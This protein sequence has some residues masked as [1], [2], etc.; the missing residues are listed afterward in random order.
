MSMGNMLL[1]EATKVCWGF[2]P[3]DLNGGTAAGDYVNFKSHRKCAVVLQTGAWAGGTS[4]VTLTQASN[5]GGTGDKA[6][7]FS[8]YYISTGLTDDTLVKTAV[9]SDTFNLSAANKLVIIEVLS[10]D[11]DTDNGFTHFR[12]NLATPGANA[13]LVS[14]LYVFYQGERAG[15]VATHP[16]VIG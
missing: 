8:H 2:A 6:L 10:T 11:L 9:V 7:A 3:I 4:A 12:V 15:S 16:S 13:D 5:A 14:G 1:V